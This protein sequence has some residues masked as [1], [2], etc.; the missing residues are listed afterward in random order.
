M[1][2]FTLVLAASVAIVAWLQWLVALNKLRLD[3]FDRRYKI[4]DTARKF[5]IQIVRHANFDDSQLFDF[6]AG[7]SDAEFLFDA[8]VVRFL[9]G[10]R[11]HAL[12]I[13]TARILL[14]DLPVGDERTRQAKIQHDAL[15]WI[16]DQLTPMTAAFNPYLGFANVRLKALPSL[17]F[18]RTK[19]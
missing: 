9:G 3:L 5:I 17:N 4:Y 15:L 2:F 18:F 1:K 19:R 7:T 16:G 12:K 6:A 8:D 10:I 11:E 14:E 13:R